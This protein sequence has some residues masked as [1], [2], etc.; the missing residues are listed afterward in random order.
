[1]SIRNLDIVAFGTPPLFCPTFLLIF[2][3]PSL[4]HLHSPMFSLSLSF[5]LCLMLIFSNYLPIFFY[6]VL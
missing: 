5:F 6:F 4:S 1:M 3:G 2:L